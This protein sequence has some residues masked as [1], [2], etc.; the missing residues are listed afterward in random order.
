MRSVPVAEAKAHF[1]ALLTA[2][3][4]G[5]EIVITRHGRQIA[6]LLPSAAKSAADIF[7]PLWADNTEDFDLIE[8]V[9]PSPGP[10]H[11]FD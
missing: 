11:G 7:R 5:E 6:R 10:V 1:S 4:G 9:D 8:P 2:A 3:E